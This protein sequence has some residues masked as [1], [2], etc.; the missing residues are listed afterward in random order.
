MK[1]E[2]S[3]RSYRRAW[4]RLSRDVFASD[5]AASKLC[6]DLNECDDMSVNDMV[7]LYNSV[8]TKLL[9]K[10]YPFVTVRRR[11]KQATPWFDADCRA[12]RRRTRATETRYRRTCSDADK[13]PWSRELQVLRQLYERKNCSYWRAEIAETKGDVKRLW[14][15]L[16][17]ILGEASNVD[18]GELTADDF[19][20]FF[21]DKV[22]S[23]RASTASTPLYDVPNKATPD[24]GAM[25]DCHQQS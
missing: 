17:G 3:H 18:A 6:S 12:A 8:L 15:T 22:E 11:D 25:D 7:E 10:H 24:V 5:L 9:A 21:K 1:A 23:V 16:H 14:R 20:V 2:I 4:R 13:L 19:D